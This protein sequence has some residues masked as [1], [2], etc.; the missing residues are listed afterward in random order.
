MCGGKNMVK[1]FSIFDFQK[2]CEVFMHAFNESWDDEWTIETAR[3]YLQELLDNKRFI[4]FTAWENDLLTGFIFCHMRYN[5]RCTTMT[6]DLM[7]VSP[8]YQRKGYGAELIDAVEKFS[9]ENS[10]TGIDLWTAEH[11]PSFKFYEK[12]GYKGPFGITM[13]KSIK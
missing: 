12:L 6:I 11:K 9:R 13:C 2:V 3:I 5:W 8:S 10:I 1:E 7:G 4:G